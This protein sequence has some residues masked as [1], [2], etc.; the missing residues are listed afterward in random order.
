MEILGLITD[1]LALWHVR[2]CR[3]LRDSI[4][5]A[6][7]VAVLLLPAA[8]LGAISWSLKLGALM[9]LIFIST[10]CT[11]SLA[12]YRS[13]MAIEISATIQRVKKPGLLRAAGAGVEDYIRLVA[14]ILASET[15]VG[16]I[17]IWLPA[18]KNPLMAILL[19]P[20]V[21]ALIT[22]AIWQKRGK[23]W[24]PK[25][26][27]GLAIFT[28]IISLV[29]IFFPRS[30]TEIAR[31]V[32]LDERIAATAKEALPLPGEKPSQP[33]AEAREAVQEKKIEVVIR[34]D[35]W[36]EAS[37]PYYHWFDFAYKDDFQVRLADGKT[38]D[39]KVGQPKPFLG[40]EIPASR[41]ELKSLTGSTGRVTIFLRPKR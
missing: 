36:T 17:A 30:T 35:Q 28:L 13:I 4:I 11:L 10:V 9:I 6:F 5:V 7:V 34:P 20:T 32:R 31:R 33:P 24:W 29:T 26:V 18:H 25:L 41:L 15:T 1:I 22:Y 14:A 38:Y 12:Y 21:M 19:M 39:F 3:R 23:F 27:Y 37:L 16:L 8:F 2:E 40:N